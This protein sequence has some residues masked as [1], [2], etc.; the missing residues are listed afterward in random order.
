MLIPAL[1]SH[2]WLPGKLDLIA[3]LLL[4]QHCSGFLGLCATLRHRVGHLTLKWTQCYEGAVVRKGCSQS[5]E[6]TTQKTVQ[7]GEGS[8]VSFLGSPSPG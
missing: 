7:E 8:G 6:L 2:S 1:T 3:A 5:L 4:S